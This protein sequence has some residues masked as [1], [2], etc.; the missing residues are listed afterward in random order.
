MINIKN[1][2]TISI[3]IVILSIML[4]F[5]FYIDKQNQL[6]MNELEEIVEKEIQETHGKRN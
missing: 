3:S 1:I 5:R 4:I 6:D 2:L